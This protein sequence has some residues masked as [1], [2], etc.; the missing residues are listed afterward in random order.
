MARVGFPVFRYRPAVA[1][2]LVSDPFYVAIEH[3]LHE[4][5]KLV[6][7]AILSRCEH[8]ERDADVAV[9]EDGVVGS[10]GRLD[11]VRKTAGNR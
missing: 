1:L 8:P 10:V 4:E 3:A 9:V 6:S 5:S 11:L 2:H 7:R